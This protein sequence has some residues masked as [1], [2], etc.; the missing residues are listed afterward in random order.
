MS[1]ACL[2]FQLLQ[3][4]ESWAIVFLHWKI[5]KSSVLVE[6]YISFTNERRLPRTHML[7]WKSLNFYEHILIHAAQL[8]TPWKFAK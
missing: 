7:V 2:G 6:M 4:C 5:R 3:A 1:F 8:A